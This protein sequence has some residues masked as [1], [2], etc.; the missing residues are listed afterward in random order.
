VNKTNT[1]GTL[2]KTHGI[3]QGLYLEYI[4]LAWNVVGVAVV[5]TAAL[6]ASSVALAGFGLDSLIEILASAVVVWQLKGVDKKREAKALRVIAVAFA[7][8][9]VYI[10]LQTTRTILFKTHP[11]SSLPGIIWLGIT[12]VVMLSLAYGNH[13]IGK[14]IENPV[15]L[16][17]GKVTLVDAYLAGAVL[18]GLT[19]NVL[20]G[21]WWADPLA[22][23][24]IVYYGIKESH[25]AWEEAK[26]LAR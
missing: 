22:G 12:F 7:L 21:W 23:I 13:K 16:T 24:V 17:E 18:I 15:L 25:H 14:K 2:E 19:L 10:L 6:K 9:A 26:T 20:L 5:I 1:S 4:T 11:Q 8:L 3:R